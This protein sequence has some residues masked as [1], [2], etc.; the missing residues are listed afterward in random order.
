VV[1]QHHKYN[2]KKL[3]PPNFFSIFFVNNKKMEPIGKLKI[4]GVLSVVL[5]L[6]MIGVSKEDFTENDDRV[7]DSS[8]LTEYEP[9]LKTPM[10]YLVVGS[11][12]DEQ[13][14]VRFTQK[15]S[16]LG[17]NFY[18]LPMT[19]GFTRVGIFTSP[20]KEDVEEYKKTVIGDFTKTWIT[21]Q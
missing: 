16:N 9:E 18:T 14:A 4:L 10:Y 15:V 11:F 19:D 5:I 8:N 17:Y 3:T 1:Q 7:V 2:N 6:L 21:Y 13:N 20:Y 12:I